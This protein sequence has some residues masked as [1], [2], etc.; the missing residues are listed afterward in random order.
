MKVCIVHD[1]KFGNGKIVAETFAESLKEAEVTIGHINRISPK[2]IV[3]DPPD[4]I[5]IGTAVRMFRIS[6]GS[7]IWLKKLHKN[8]M[9]SGKKI[10]F[11]AGFVTHM[12][13]VN[14]VSSRIEGYYNLLHETTSIA[15]IYPNWLLG[16][17][18]AIEG[19]LKD[20]V[21]DKIRIG[22]REMIKWMDQKT[23]QIVT[24]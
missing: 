19:P 10:D 23:D 8:L 7:K 3:E 18:E 22:A 13:D 20:G 14:K 9:K 17:V 21:L 5:I 1:S 24:N 2:S 12:R 4:L 16:Q 11:G 15:N 6:R